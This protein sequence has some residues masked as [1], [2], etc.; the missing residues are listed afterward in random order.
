MEL[1]SD[2]TAPVSGATNLIPLTLAEIKKKLSHLGVMDDDI[3]YLLSHSQADARAVAEQKDNL[4]VDMQ[5]NFRSATPPPSTGMESPINWGQ[6]S[7]LRTKKILGRV[8]F[9]INSPKFK[10][11]FN[12]QLSCLKASTFVGGLNGADVIPNNYQ[13]FKQVVFNALAK[14]DGHYNLYAYNKISGGNAYGGV[15]APNMYFAPNQLDNSPMN[16]SAPL[17]LHELTHTF[18]YQHA[19]I[20]AGNFTPSNLPYYVQMITDNGGMNERDFPNLIDLY[21]HSYEKGYLLPDSD[22]NI[23]VFSQYFGNS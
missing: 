22:L 16:Q 13:G 14:S 18:G 23:D 4:L 11:R 17:L 12:S 20:E 6:Q 1:Q 8:A 3:E 15:G 10:H 5:W 2:A 19:G 9:V 7:L 21:H